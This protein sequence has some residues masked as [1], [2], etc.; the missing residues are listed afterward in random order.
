MIAKNM[1]YKDYLMSIVDSTDNDYEEIE[2]IIARYQTLRDARNDL[3][4]ACEKQNDEILKR[5][6]EYLQLKSTSQNQLLIQSGILNA[7]RSELEH[8]L[9]LLKNEQDE[10]EVLEDEKKDVMREY[11]Q[12]NQAIRNIFHRCQ[13]ASKAMNSGGMEGNSNSNNMM[14]Q[15]NKLGGNTMGS[16]KGLNL[17]KTVSGGGNTGLVVI[18]W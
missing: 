10:S 4:S 5:R 1:S 2:E 12:I 9:N 13:V 7:Y 3:M 16:S 18:Q 8:L 17:N 11:S 6:K 15:S 14:N